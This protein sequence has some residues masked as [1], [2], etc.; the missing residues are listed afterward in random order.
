V[1]Y[2]KADS[3]PVT[4]GSEGSVTLVGA[5]GQSGWSVALAPSSRGA[6]TADVLIGAP[7][8]RQGRVYQVFGGAIGDGLA[9]DRLGSRG[10]RYAG[11]TDLGR[12]GNSVA[13]LGASVLIGE[14]E[15]MDADGYILAGAAHLMEPATGDLS[16]PAPALAF[17]T[18]GSYQAAEFGSYCWDGS[19]VDRVPTF[20]DEL[21]RAGRGDRAQ[22]HISLPVVPDGFALYEYRQLDDLGRPAGAERELE[23]ELTRRREEVVGNFVLPSHRGPSY[24]V[25]V[26]R[27]EGLDRGDT[28]HFL[29]LDLGDPYRP[30]P[31]TPWTYLHAG[32]RQRAGG[33]ESWGWTNCYVNGHCTHMI[34]DT[35]VRT[36]PVR[37]LAAPHGGDV[38]VRIRTPFR[39][40]AWRLTVH[41]RL[42]DFFFPAGRGRTV[43]A[44]LHPYRVDGERVAW[45]ARF[46]L[47]SSGERVFYVMHALWRG[48]GEIDH[49]FHV[50]LE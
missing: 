25:A 16:H 47:P 50:R 43:D 15:G 1:V 42:D 34:A 21:E 12:F 36:E 26:A 37:P 11:T 31:G 24:L 46:E 41:A 20:P 19:C 29:A 3:H 18:Y 23:V 13:P 39:P 4:L 44:T 48:H 32:G 38:F 27:W 45:D 33:S 7:F 9:L 28:M 22:L 14:P 17:T 10:F 49:D 8:K 40:D 6:E 30:M 35:A 2:G 5:G